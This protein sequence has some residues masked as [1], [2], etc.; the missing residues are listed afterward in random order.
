VAR[1]HNPAQLLAALLGW[2][3]PRERIID[4]HLILVAGELAE[5]ALKIQTVPEQD[6]GPDTRGGW[7]EP[8]R[9]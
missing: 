8:V 9:I 2:C 5:L 4:A 7:W 1:W 6:N 3:L